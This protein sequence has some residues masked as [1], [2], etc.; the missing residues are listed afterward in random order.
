MIWRE[1]RVLL[2]ILGVL[3]V[4]NAIFFFTYR[5]QYEARLQGLDSRLHDAEG[6]LQH[7]REKRIA[8]E[9][10]LASYNKAESDLESLYNKTWSTKPQRLTALIN[11]LKKMAVATQLDPNTIS[12]SETQDR[13]AEKNGGI[14]TSTVTI[15]FTVHGTYQQVRQLINQL[16]LSRQFVIID[17]IHLSSSGPAN[18]DLTLTLRLKTVFREPGRSLAM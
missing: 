3:L 6:E 13:D 8:A 11:E 5:V 1:H 9:R 4:A 7:A 12:F 10:L 18:G 2:T 15:S 14:G 16:E 17:A